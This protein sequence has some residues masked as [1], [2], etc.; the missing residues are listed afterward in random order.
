MSVISPAVNRQNAM[1]KP[2]RDRA[3]MGGK[4]ALE[5]AIFMAELTAELADIARRHH[6]DVLAYLLEMARLE[7]EH[8]RRELGEGRS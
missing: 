6:L 8:V 4:D 1:D 7:A 3:S 5:A 2:R